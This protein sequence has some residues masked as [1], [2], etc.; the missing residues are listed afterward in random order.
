MVR[1][2]SIIIP[3]YEKYEAL[4][5]TW[6]ELHLQL[7]PDD[8]VLVVDDWSPNGVPDFDCP[9]TKIIRPPKHEPHI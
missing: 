6:E 8:Q 5:K 2:L 9:C 4:K 3:F 1:N 7:H